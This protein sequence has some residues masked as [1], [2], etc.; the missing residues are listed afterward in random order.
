MRQSSRLPILFASAAVALVLCASAQA[1]PVTVGSPLTGAFKSEGSP[2]FE[3]T[4]VIPTLGESG[5][6]TVSPVTGAIVRWHLLDAEGGPFRL[7]VLRPVGGPIY[8]GVGSSAPASPASTGFETF[9]TALPIQA[10]DTVG[11]DIPA[12]VK[13]GVYL[14]G[15]ASSVAIWKPP[16]AEGATRPIDQ[17]EAG[18]E[19]GFNAEV[20]PTPGITSIGPASGSIKGG[21]SVTITGTDLEGASA[22]S[23]GGV[24]AKSFGVSSES[25]IT[26]VT[27]AGSKV[28]GVDL[29]V[30]T[31]AGTTPLVTADKFTYKGCVVP[32]LK[33]KKLKADRKKLKKAD[34][35]LGTVK[36]H[37]SK[38][39]RVKKQN[40]KPGKVLAPGAK[41]NVK[42]GG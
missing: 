37:K 40:P 1:A 24:A 4:A 9:A 19:Y 32:K 5:A 33:G 13:L 10:G 3:F 27:P 30:T 7:R 16:L 39:A 38:S 21:T 36:G 26:A 41:V 28:G 23:F 42:L 20:Q 17:E 35:K 11:L 29:S 22:V 18:G 25:A 14:S 6:H 12:G 15:P 8:T 31:V 34:C 2:G